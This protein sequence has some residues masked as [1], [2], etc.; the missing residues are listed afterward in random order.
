[1]SVAKW[2]ACALFMQECAAE[3]ETTGGEAGGWLGGELRRCA[4][5]VYT[6]YPQTPGGESASFTTEFKIHYDK[7]TTVPTVAV[8][9]AGDVVT[10]G[11]K[12]IAAQHHYVA[13]VDSDLCADWLTRSHM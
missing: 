11:P 3:M 9:G 1:M 4:V 8:H 5:R 6:M 2:R 7:A 12:L 10:A 13:T